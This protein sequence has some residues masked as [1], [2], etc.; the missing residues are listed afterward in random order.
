M[1]QVIDI[2]RNQ[3]SEAVTARLDLQQQQQQH[4]QQQQ[5]Y[6]DSGDDSSELLEYDEDYDRYV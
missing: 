4:Q 3:W 2:Q 6:S 1:L 5:Q